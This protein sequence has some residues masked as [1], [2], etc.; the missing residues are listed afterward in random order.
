MSRYTRAHIYLRIYVLSTHTCV[1]ECVYRWQAFRQQTLPFNRGLFIQRWGQ[2]FAMLLYTLYACAREC[3]WI[4]TGIQST[5][6]Y[7]TKPSTLS[8]SKFDIKKY[9]HKSHKFGHFIFKT[10]KKVETE[11]RNHLIFF[12][13]LTIHFEI[14]C[15]DYEQLMSHTKC[16]NI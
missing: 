5:I 1:F 10:R 16:S 3:M 4:S 14:W 13:L 2:C 15:R 9:T 6:L 8:D 7:T 12:S 11:T